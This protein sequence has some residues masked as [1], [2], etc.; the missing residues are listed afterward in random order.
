MCVNLMIGRD[1][2]KYLEPVILQAEGGCVVVVVGVRRTTCFLWT[3]GGGVVIGVQVHPQ[4]A[5]LPSVH[6]LLS[7]QATVKPA[8]NF[9]IDT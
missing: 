3:G 1:Y 6:G 2:K 7:P 9:F 8:T 4:P 5:Y